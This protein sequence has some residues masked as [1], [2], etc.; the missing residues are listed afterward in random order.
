MVSKK[1]LNSATKDP[2]I[3][4]LV[5]LPKDDPQYPKKTYTTMFIAASFVIFRNCKKP[6][7][8]STKEWV[9]KMLFI[10]IMECYS[11]IKNRDIM[12]FKG[13]W[14]ELENLIL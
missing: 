6:K 10:Y 4:L 13:K 7:Y 9:N 8:S 2:T 1:I 11:G 12:D 14:M 5:I 3:P